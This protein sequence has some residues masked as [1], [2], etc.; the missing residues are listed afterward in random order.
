M[1]GEAIEAVKVGAHALVGALRQDPRAREEAR[2]TVLGY[3]RE[4]WE[5]CA[6][7]GMGEFRMPL[8]EASEAEESCLGRALEVVGGRAPQEGDWKPMLFVMTD[9]EVTDLGRYREQVGK[10]RGNFA[11]VVG[12][13]AGGGAREEILRE[14]TGEVGD[15]E[16]MERGILGGYL[17]YVS[18]EGER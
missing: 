5:W 17:R 7:T 3:D 14:L 8:V 6:P 18:P 2:L 4:V 12:C 9:G 1:R 15:L 13:L 11:G 16:M 10:V